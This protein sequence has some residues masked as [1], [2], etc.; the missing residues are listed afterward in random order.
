MAD[1]DV[2]SLSRLFAAVGSA[3]PAQQPGSPLQTVLEQVAQEMKIGVDP[4]PT[5]SETRHTPPTRKHPYQ[6]CLPGITE[7][8]HW[9]S[10][11]SERLKKSSGPQLGNPS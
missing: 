10:V 7:F 1:L 3:I 4:I 2:D 11:Q 6:S 9:R 8:P 5:W